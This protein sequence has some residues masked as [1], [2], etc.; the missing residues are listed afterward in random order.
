MKIIENALSFVPSLPSRSVHH[1]E[2][3]LAT[4]IR[5]IA[6]LCLLQ[7]SCPSPSAR[8]TP[9]RWRPTQTGPGR[10]SSLKSGNCRENI[11]ICVSIRSEKEA[12]MVYQRPSRPN[13]CPHLPTNRF[14]A[15][16]ARHV[17]SSLRDD[18]A[19]LGNTSFHT[20]AVYRLSI[21]PRRVCTRSV[22]A[23]Y[24]SHRGHPFSAAPVP[25]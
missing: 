20:H 23:M 17:R 21:H 8:C 12:F 14:P 10:A 15:R 19:S 6:L 5:R 18:H 3:I 25:K 1:L 9:L 11:I 7:S 22:H 13:T 4:Y 24:R 2:R 16:V